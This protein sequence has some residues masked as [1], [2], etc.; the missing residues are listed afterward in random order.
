ME[1]KLTIIEKGKWLLNRGGRKFSDV[2]EDEKGEYV[3]MGDGGFGEKKVYLG[4]SIEEDTIPNTKYE[5]KG[6]IKSVIGWS[7]M[8]NIGR[9]QLKYRFDKYGVEETLDKLIKKS[10]E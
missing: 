8:T 7:K 3:L 1:N 10:T 5:Y 2:L 9:Y 4:Q 6:V